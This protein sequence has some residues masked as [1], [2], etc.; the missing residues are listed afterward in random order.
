[1]ILVGFLNIALVGS[2]IGIAIAVFH[3]KGKRRI[4][5]GVVCAA[6]TIAMYV[7]PLE[8]MV[9]HFIDRSFLFFSFPFSCIFLHSVLNYNVTK[10]KH[11]V[12]RKVF[13][14]RAGTIHVVPR[15]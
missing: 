7:A 14:C 15:R 10:D 1:M 12:S 5:M 11:C 2:V 9:T 3:D 13:G 8:A 4:F 6:V